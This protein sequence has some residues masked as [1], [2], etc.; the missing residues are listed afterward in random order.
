M[1]RLT[2]E[3]FAYARTIHPISWGRGLVGVVPALIA[4]FA[5]LGVL[6]SYPAL[7]LLTEPWL[8]LL[9]WMR[10]GVS[11]SM[12]P[13]VAL[14]SNALMLTATVVLSLWNHVVYWR[15]RDKWLL[16]MFHIDYQPT[17]KKYWSFLALAAAF[18][19]FTVLQV[20][21]SGDP[22]WASGFSTHHRFGLTVRNLMPLGAAVIIGFVP[23]NIYLFRALEAFNRSNHGRRQ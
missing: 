15:E 18:V 2:P 10:H 21:I 12:F 1:P 8:S 7:R 4:L 5:P 6:S 9:P 20:S 23:T 17:R 13:E 3:Q 11:A 16:L 19:F 22:S 14:L